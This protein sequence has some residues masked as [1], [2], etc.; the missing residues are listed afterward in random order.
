[1]GVDWLGRLRDYLRVPDHGAEFHRGAAITLAARLYNEFRFP[2]KVTTLAVEGLML[3]LVADTVRLAKQKHEHTIPPRIKLAKE[4]LYEHF[5]ESI[6]L[7]QIAKA[8][9]THPVYLARA[10]HRYYRSPIGEFVRRLR[11]EF[12]CSKLSTSDEPL[13]NIALAAGFCDQ[14]H[15]SRAVKLMTGMSPS[16]Y[17]KAHRH[18]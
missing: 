4:F 7:E 13:A 6:S 15:L 18:G 17:R 3:E 9:D 1:M 5:H 16:I 11:V 10:F 12:A 2:D 8:V 14:S